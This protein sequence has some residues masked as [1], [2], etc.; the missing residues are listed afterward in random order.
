[1][2]ATRI[3]AVRRLHITPLVTIQHA[4]FR[5]QYEH[6]LACSLFEDHE[7]PGPLHDLYLVDMFRLARNTLHSFDVHH[8]QTLYA[9]LGF[10]RHTS[11]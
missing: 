9:H 8:E 6:G 10:T 11:F 5:D 1:M 3:E 4:A 2:A 7:T